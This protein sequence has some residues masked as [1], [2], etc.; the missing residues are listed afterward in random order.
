LSCS[1]C[2]AFAIFH[3][4]YPRFAAAGFAAETDIALPAYAT[5]T[6]MLWEMPESFPAFEVIFIW[7]T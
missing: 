3:Y 6:V 7:V 2:R 4:R 1:S 5:S